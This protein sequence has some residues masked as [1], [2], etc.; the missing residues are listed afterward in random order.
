MTPAKI[1]LTVNSAYS[2]LEH[3]CMFNT[4]LDRLLCRTKDLELES[5]RNHRRM[6]EGLGTYRVSPETVGRL[7]T[8][9]HTIRALRTPPKPPANW[10]E[11]TSIAPRV[12]SAY[13][14]AHLLSERLEE[15]SSVVVAELLDHS[16]MVID[17]AEHCCG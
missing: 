14:L 9:Q 1:R 2:L 12:A 7:F 3:A 5:E 10:G 4:E 16:V 15:V 11:V 13:G 8:A 17:Y 6:G